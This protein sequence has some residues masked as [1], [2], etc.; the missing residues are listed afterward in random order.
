MD[1]VIGFQFFTAS[2]SFVG[3]YIHLGLTPIEQNDIDAFCGK[4][5]A[6]VLHSWAS[7]D[8][9]KYN[10]RSRNHWNRM[11]TNKGKDKKTQMN[12]IVE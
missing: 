2:L 6:V 1:L 7:P 11:I 10:D 4:R 3:N 5:Q 12:T 8:I 9:A